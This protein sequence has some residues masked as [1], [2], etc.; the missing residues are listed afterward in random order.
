M[1]SLLAEHHL[2]DLPRERGIHSFRM[3]DLIAVWSQRLD[4]DHKLPKR[5][6]IDT[7][8]LGDQLQQRV[9]VGVL[10]ALTIEEHDRTNTELIRLHREAIFCHESKTAGIIETTVDFV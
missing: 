6:L 2:T 1:L 8:W 5:L 9:P 7:A 10:L 4:V 3:R